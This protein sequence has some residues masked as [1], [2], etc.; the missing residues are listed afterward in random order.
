MD[1]I[2]CMKIF[3]RTVFLTFF[4][5]WYKQQQRKCSI[6]DCTLKLYCKIVKIK[7]RLL[8]FH[9][10]LFSERKRFFWFFKH[11][12][13]RGYYFIF[14]TSHNLSLK[15]KRRLIKPFFPK[16]KSFPI[17]LACNKTCENYIFCATAFFPVIFWIID[18]I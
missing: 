11:I 16:T 1:Q 13:S 3:K 5:F 12:P 14:L 4:S 15:I 7:R 10:F 17:N 18:Y 6:A 8:C 9:P 2:K